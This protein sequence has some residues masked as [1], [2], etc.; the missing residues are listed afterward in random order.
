MS[1][2]DISPEGVGSVLTS[3][4]GYVGDEA[5]TEGLTGQIEDFGKHLQDAA[6]DAA[7]E[8]IA[9]ALD[10]FLDHFGPKMWGMVGRTSSA[11]GGAG[12]ATKA[13]MNGN[14]DMA[15]EAQANVGDISELDL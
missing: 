15:E 7:S 12:E 2:W 9:T 14:L 1:G 8:P 11:I 10:E 4:G 3:V 13:Y 6:E 5:M